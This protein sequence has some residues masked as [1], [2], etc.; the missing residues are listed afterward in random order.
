MKVSNDFV[1]FCVQ[2]H[3]VIALAF[4]QYL[5]GLPLFWDLQ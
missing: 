2:F 1:Y 3:E 5:L 4:T